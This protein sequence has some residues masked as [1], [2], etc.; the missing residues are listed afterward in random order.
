MREL[1]RVL[2]DT[3]RDAAARWDPPVSAGL[4]RVP[5]LQ[6]EQLHAFLR[7]VTSLVVIAEAA[8]LVMLA[9]IAS[10]CCP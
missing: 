8:L 4:R 3:A 5:G 9:A 10:C 2:A 6:L 7:R 1:E